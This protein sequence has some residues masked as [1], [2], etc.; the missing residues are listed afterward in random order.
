M[1]KT[2]ANRRRR[3][4]SQR[5][6]S[7]CDEKWI[8]D[9]KESNGLGVRKDH[10]SDNGRSMGGEDWSSTEKEVRCTRFQHTIYPQ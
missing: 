5:E 3:G 9:S 10:A 2:E 8:R 4:R 6:A 1:K 7:S